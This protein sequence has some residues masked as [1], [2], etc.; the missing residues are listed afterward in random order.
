MPCSH[1]I[2][3]ISAYCRNHDSFTAYK[4]GLFIVKEYQYCYATS[5]LESQPTSR[6]GSF[7]AEDDSHSNK[8]EKGKDKGKGVASTPDPQTS[9]GKKT[10]Q[11]SLQRAKSPRIILYVRDF[12]YLSSRGENNFAPHAR[13][14][15]EAI[16]RAWCQEIGAERLKE[17]TKRMKA[18]A[19][20]KSALVRR[21]RGQTRIGCTRCSISG[22]HL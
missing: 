17:S 15:D 10:T 22:S 5:Y 20:R 2:L 13:S 8:S 12:K 19:G 3:S 7:V 21:A 16:G 1:C 4:G 14:F 6:T 11:A 9:P 18:G